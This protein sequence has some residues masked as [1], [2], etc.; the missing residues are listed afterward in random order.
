MKSGLNTDLIIR[1]KALLVKE[2]PD[3]I[4]RC[5][6]DALRFTLIDYTQNIRQLNLDI[7]RVYSV[8]HF[9]NKIWNLFRY[10][11]GKFEQKSFRANGHDQPPEAAK[12]L[13]NQFIL[14]RFVDTVQKIES[15]FER[16]E[17]HE[18]T[19][20]LNKFI[21]G[22]LCDVF[23]EFSKPVFKQSQD[24][25]EVIETLNTLWFCLANSL[26]ILHPFMPF[27]TEVIF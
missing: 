6:A 4:Q 24:S 14:S 3:G 21:V 22:D 2:F 9:C 17:L 27:L 8:S 5:G 11:Y 1:A 18:C 23:V 26:K 15:G 19:T 12:F 16:F 10:S 7:N 13:L 20:A 25:E